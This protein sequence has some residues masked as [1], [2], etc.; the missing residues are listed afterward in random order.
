MGLISAFYMLC[1]PQYM[2]R[3]AIKNTGYNIAIDWFVMNKDQEWS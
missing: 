3:A 1:S 2:I